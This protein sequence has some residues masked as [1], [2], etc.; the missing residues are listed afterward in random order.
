MIWRGYLQKDPVVGC[1]LLFVLLTGIGVSGLR[2]EFG[3]AQSV[4][5]RYRI[6]S[7]LLLIFAWFALVKMNQ[8]A[9]VPL[10]RRNRLFVIIVAMSASFCIVMDGIGVRNLRRRDQELEHG[11]AIFER[12]GGLQSPIYSSDG[13]V[14]GYVG[15]DEHAREVLI[16]S[17]KVG[18]YEPR[19]Y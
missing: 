10:L 5:S 18:T 8:M 13:H 2:A 3:L 19:S 15:F 17:E 12:S 4:S 16:E 11:M 6:Y 9:E 7:D 1:C 14:Q